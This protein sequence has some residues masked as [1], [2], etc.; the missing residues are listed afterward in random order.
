[1][2]TTAPAAAS[3]GRSPPLRPGS[4]R[5]RPGTLVRILVGAERGLEGSVVRRVRIPR[6]SQLLSLYLVVLLDGVQRVLPHNSLAEVTT[7]GACIRLRSVVH[8]AS[9]PHLESHR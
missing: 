2:G 8:R 5:Y 4:R 6:H 7:P 9:P 3:C 1:M